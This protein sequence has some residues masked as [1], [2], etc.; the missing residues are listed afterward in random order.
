MSYSCCYKHLHKLYHAIYELNGF[1]VWYL[2]VDST[3][4]THIVSHNSRNQSRWIP[5]LSLIFLPPIPVDVC[6]VVDPEPGTSK[7]IGNCWNVFV[8]YTDS[9]YK[10][11]L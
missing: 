6:S 10:Y 5:L 3:F 2:K 9:I 1:D 4:V 7:L 8:A 11:F